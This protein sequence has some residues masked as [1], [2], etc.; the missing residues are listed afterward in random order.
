MMH[1][2]TSPITHNQKGLLR[3]VPSPLEGMRY[4]SLIV[5]RK[6]IPSELQIIA[7]EKKS[8]IVMAVQHSERPLFGIQ[9]HPESIGT[10]TG[11]QILQN[12][13]AI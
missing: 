9:F 2:K 6:S 13:L 5:D 3:G 4:H 10:S 11:K 7:E 1:G 12:F 8:K